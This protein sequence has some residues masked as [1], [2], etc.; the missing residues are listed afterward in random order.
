MLPSQRMSG[1]RGYRP[2]VQNAKLH[3]ERMEKK[4]APYRFHGK[5]DAEVVATVQ[6]SPIILRWLEEWRA[7]RPN[8]YSDSR[9][10]SAKSKDR[11]PFY[12][13]LNWLAEQTG[14]DQ[15]RISKIAKGEVDFISLETADRLLTAMGMPHKLT[16]E[17]QVVPNPNWSPERWAE[18]MR[19]RGC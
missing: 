15:R 6:I 2:S 10:F 16:S 3:K 4:R 17:I 18:Y 14:L 9:N 8:V 5:G 12:G 1:I 7:E 19:E 11:N 13:A